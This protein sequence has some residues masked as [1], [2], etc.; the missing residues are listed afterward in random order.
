MGNMD[1]KQQILSLGGPTKVAE[2]LGL[3]KTSGGVQRVQNWMTR[4]IP[5]QVKLDHPDLFPYRASNC[6]TPSPQSIVEA[7]KKR[8]GGVRLPVNPERLK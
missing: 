4:G 2:L 1:D 8:N 7:E 5:A 3:D 6:A